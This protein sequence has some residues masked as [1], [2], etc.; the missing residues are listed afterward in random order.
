MSHLAEHSNNKPKEISFGNQG[1]TVLVIRPLFDP[2]FCGIEQGLFLMPS[3]NK[4]D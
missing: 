1:G 4:L 3:I 2:T